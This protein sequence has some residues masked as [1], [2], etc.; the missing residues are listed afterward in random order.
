MYKK[1]WFLCTLEH[2]Y[3]VLFIYC[4]KHLGISLLDISSEDQIAG[5]I[6]LV[7]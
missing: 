4:T 3:I 6:N 7:S 2:S 1:V 5:H